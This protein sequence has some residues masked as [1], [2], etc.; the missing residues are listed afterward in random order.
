MLSWGY[1]YR[2]GINMPQPWEYYHTYPA[3]DINSTVADMGKYLNMHLNNGVFNN[4]KILSAELAKLMK[5]PQLR[6]HKKV[7]AFAYGFYEEDAHGFRTISHGGDMQGYSS[8]MAMVAEKKLGVFI[9]HHHEGTRLRY[10]IMDEILKT[11]KED[12]QETPL[13]PLIEKT[14]LDKLAGHYMWTTHCHS[15]VDGWKPNRQELVVNDDQTFTIMNRTY[16]EIEP[17][18]FK[19]T[20]GMRI[21]SFVENETGVIEYMSLGGVNMFEKVD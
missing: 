4:E 19:S 14:E 8:Y 1:E 17:L 2:N 12:R 5:Q 15:C 3:S 13:K 18:L 6:V 16:K 9:V 10:A 20:D 21:I 7:E 11:F